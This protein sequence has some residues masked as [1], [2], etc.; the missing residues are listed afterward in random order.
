MA[1]HS[2][3]LAWRISW[4]EEPGGLQSMGSQRG[5]HS[6]VTKDST[7]PLCAYD[8]PDP[9]D[10]RP[11]AAG[12]LGSLQL[13]GVLQ[14]QA[15]AFP[16]TPSQWLQQGLCLGHPSSDSSRAFAPAPRWH[17]D[18]HSVPSEGL[19]AQQGPGVGHPGCWACCPAMWSNWKACPC[20]HSLTKHRPQEKRK[21]NH[22]SILALRT[23]WI[24]WKGKKIRHWKMNPSGW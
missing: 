22:F 13:L 20:R 12:R 5:G 14:L 10:G 6:W 2:S 8:P 23:P 19:Y 7:A 1:T 18:W 15:P 21:A 24:Q 3:I 17:I 16:R 4:T 11:A 9:P